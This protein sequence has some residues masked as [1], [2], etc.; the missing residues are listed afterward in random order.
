M[1]NVEA[2]RNYNFPNI[3]IE[4][5]TIEDYSVI[6]KIAKNFNDYKYD[7]QKILSFLDANPTIRDFNKDISREWKK[8]RN[9]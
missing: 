6:D 3:E 2:P 9:N 7:L 1:L 8:F 4:L 5:D